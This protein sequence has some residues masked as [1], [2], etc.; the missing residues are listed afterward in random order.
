[1]IRSKQDLT[2]YLVEDKRAL[3]IESKRPRFLADEIWKFQIAL[4]KC[5]YYKNCGGN[6]IAF[7]INRLIRHRLGVKLGYD[8]PLNVCGKG[9]RLAH[10]GYVAINSGAIVGDYCCIHPGVIIGTSAGESHA[11]PTIGERVHIGPGAKVIGPITI[12]SDIAIGANAVVTH[13]FTE[14]NVALGGVPAKVISRRGSAGY[15]YCGPAI[16]NR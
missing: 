14:P 9:L 13:D 1:M 7:A 8:I 11:A 4:R 15:L 2:D 12:A 10:R 16:L 6:R 3:G 5:E